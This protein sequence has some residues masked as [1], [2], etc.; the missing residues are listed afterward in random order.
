MPSH[1]SHLLQPLDVGCF[2][3][4]K[5]AY[6]NQISNLI[7]CGINHVTKLE[8]LPAFHTAFNASI[9]SSNISGAFRGSGLIPYDPEAVL[10]KL[11]VRLKTPT[12]SLADSLP[13]ESQTPGNAVEFVSQGQ[14]ITERI[15]RH[16]SSSLSPILNAVQQLQ[17]GAMRQDHRITL[18]EAEVSSLR[19]A[20]KLATQRRKQKRKQI[21]QSGSLTVQDGQDL[22][23]QREVNMQILEE[24]RQSSRTI[25]MSATRQRRCGRCRQP[26]HRIETCPQPNLEDLEALA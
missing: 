26:G 11:D 14:L 9:T 15:V 17:K 13:W 5:L 3:P 20:N 8:F 16:Q 24:V 2:A 4:L 7:R 19:T 12:P 18:L 21:R 10:S 22:L 6:G 1:S 23:A 25:G